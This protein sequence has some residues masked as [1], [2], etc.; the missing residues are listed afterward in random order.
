M[1]TA[2]SIPNDVFKEAERLAEQLR[3]SRS[4]LYARALAEFLVRHDADR[5]TDAMNAVID[6][7][8]LDR[9]PFTQS[10]ARRALG[11]IEW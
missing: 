3:T 2:V 9:D 1:K 7:V 5:V 10:A 8:G 11:R 4:E 6:E